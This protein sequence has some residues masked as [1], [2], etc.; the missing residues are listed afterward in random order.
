MRSGWSVYRAMICRSIVL[1]ARFIVLLE[2][3]IRDKN[4]PAFRAA[5]SQEAEGRKPCIY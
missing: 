3:E 1:S 4:N 2:F 5:I